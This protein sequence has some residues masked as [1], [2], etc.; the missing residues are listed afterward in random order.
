M[1]NSEL[2]EEVFTGF[3]LLKRKSWIYRF[4]P[5]SHPTTIDFIRDN[6]CLFPLQIV[7]I[8]EKTFLGQ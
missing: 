3:S 7:Q 1:N 2:V 4:K 6:L 5:V 8:E